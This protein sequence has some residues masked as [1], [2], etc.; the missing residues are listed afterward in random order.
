MEVSFMFSMFI[1][2]CV[3]LFALT[4]GVKITAMVLSPLIKIVVV[5]VCI[6]AA[7]AIF[8]AVEKSKSPT[9]PV[10]TK[11]ADGSVSVKLK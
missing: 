6:M 2:G 11:N 5:C 8:F 3:L 1:T 7:L 4:V 9:L 10:E